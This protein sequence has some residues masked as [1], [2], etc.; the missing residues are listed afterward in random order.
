MTTVAIMQPYFFPYA[1]YFRLFAQCDHFVLYDC[2]QFPRRGWVHRNRLPDATGEAQW[3]TLPID[4]APQEVAI[5]DLGFAKDAQQRFAEA[6]RRFPSLGRPAEALPAC[7]RVLGGS[8]VDWL[9]DSLRESCARL[10][11]RSK[12][13]RSS[14]LEIGSA[15]R[16]QDRILAI[17]KALGGTRYLNAPGGRDLYD[18]EVFAAA[19]IELSFLEPYQGPSWSILQRFMTEEAGDL[20][21]EIR[22]EHRQLSLT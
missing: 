17:V 20:A 6:C 2:V 1:G 16:G 19:G 13:I 14:S 11:L 8:L 4:K 12:M 7:F 3:L 15:L 22:G 18:P 9:E 5:R 21:A 10:G